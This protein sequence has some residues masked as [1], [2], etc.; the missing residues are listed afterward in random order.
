MAKNKSLDKENGLLGE[1]DAGNQSDGEEIISPSKLE[2]SKLGLTSKKAN[3]PD[4][5]YSMVVKK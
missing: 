3:P 2:S 4:G 5:R 1:I